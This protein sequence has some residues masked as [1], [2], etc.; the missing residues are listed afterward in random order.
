MLQ[1]NSQSS[2]SKQPLFHSENEFVFCLDQIDANE[3]NKDLYD[4]DELLD[5]DE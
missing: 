1:L 4:E 3:H 2:D 5:K